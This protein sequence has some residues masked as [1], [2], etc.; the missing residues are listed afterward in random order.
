MLR[1]GI[2][3]N[4][5]SVY[6]FGEMF[7]NESMHMHLTQMSYALPPFITSVNKKFKVLL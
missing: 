2:L 4:I 3:G 5:H 1:N 7:F 6:I